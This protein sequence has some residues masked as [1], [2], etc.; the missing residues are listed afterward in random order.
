MKQI[1]L[2]PAG[3]TAVKVAIFT[4]LFAFVSG[5]LTIM[6]MDDKGLGFVPALLASVGIIVASVMAL[7]IGVLAIC[8]AAVTLKSKYDNWYMRK[9][10]KKD[11]EKLAR[12]G[13]INPKHAK[14][15][16][17]SRKTSTKKTTK[18]STSKKKSAK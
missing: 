13:L 12:K 2:T 16:T 8:W 6:L 1:V 4:T 11:L 9:G 10:F 15:G 5:I 3:K 17:S 14:V 18:R 7:M